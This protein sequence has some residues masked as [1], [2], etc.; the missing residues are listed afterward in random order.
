MELA[1]TIISIVAII[2]LL[3]VL[4][5][6]RKRERAE[7]QQKEKLTLDR[8]L[9]MVEYQLVELVKEDNFFG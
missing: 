1:L 6:R 3:I 8:L 4:F 7:L 5:I 2:V 9:D